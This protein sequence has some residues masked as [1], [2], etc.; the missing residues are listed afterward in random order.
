MFESFCII[1]WYGICWHFRSHRYS[2]W[3]EKYDEIHKNSEYSSTVCFRA[4][5]PE[6]W[7][8]GKLLI[9]IS[10]WCAKRCNRTPCSCCLVLSPFKNAFV[11]WIPKATAN[12]RYTK[13]T[14]VYR[15]L[16]RIFLHWKFVDFVMAK[17]YKPLQIS[18]RDNKMQFKYSKW[19]HN[20]E[21]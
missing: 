6:H 10:H 12:K 21:Q 7:K 20:W 17:A 3:Y 19:N 13:Y 2:I 1:R 5:R 9:Y 15:K 16:F 11:K 8:V 4:K 14:F 18:N